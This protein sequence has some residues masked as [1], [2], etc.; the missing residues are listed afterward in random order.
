MKRKSKKEG[1]K[2]RLVLSPDNLLYYQTSL[3]LNTD[4][5][6]FLFETKDFGKP[7]ALPVAKGKSK[8]GKK[9]AIK[10][11]DYISDDLTICAINLDTACYIVKKFNCKEKRFYVL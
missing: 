7:D 1:L 5:S 8:M 3:K 11:E 6:W 2:I 4:I 9:F 10:I